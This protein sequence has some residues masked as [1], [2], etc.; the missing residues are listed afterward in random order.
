MRPVA[1]SAHYSDVLGACPRRREV[2][3]IAEADGHSQAQV[4]VPPRL[5]RQAAQH[6]RVGREGAVGLERHPP[7]GDRAS[8]PPL[9]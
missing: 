4:A 8:H 6:R 1:P 2:G 7:E 5:L 3:V 9:S